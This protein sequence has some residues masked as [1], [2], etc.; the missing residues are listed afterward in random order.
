MG[1]IRE[2]E[3][4]IQFIDGCANVVPNKVLE[5]NYWNVM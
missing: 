5:E 4:S 3:M 1:R 2:T